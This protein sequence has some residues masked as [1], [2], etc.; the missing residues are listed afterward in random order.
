MVRTYRAGILGNCC[1]HGAGL[2]HGLAGHPRVD[3]VAGYEKGERRGA[4]LAQAMGK[5]LASGYDAIIEDPTIDIAVIACDP[6]DKAYMAEK[7]CA[8]GKHIFHNKPMCHDLDSARRIV[9]AVRASGVKFVHDI[10]MV[11][12]LPATA[13]LMGEVAAGTYGKIVS[14]YHAFGM[15]FDPAFDIRGTWP[16]RFDP[17]AVAGGGEM[18]NMGCYALD[19]AVAIMGAPQAVEAKWSRFWDAYRE[20]DVENFGQIVLHYPDHY[21]L[22]SV[23]KQQIPGER[24]GNNFVSIL[25]ENAN[26]QIDPY[27]ETLI[28]NGIRNDFAEYL[29]SYEHESSLDQFLRCIE[30]NEEPTSSAEV[31]ALGVEVLMAAYHSIVQGGKLIELPLADGANPLT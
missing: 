21:A 22:L 31:G 13:K 1:T 7:C 11:R 23:G 5:D 16:E 27:S 19:Y 8:V 26:V 2:A 17:P 12:F 10:P 9:R 6:C 29:A 28:V 15:T 4:E 3:A 30:R 25:F 20:A 24:Q 14:Y 18:T